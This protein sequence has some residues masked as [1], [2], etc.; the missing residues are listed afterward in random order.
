LPPVPAHRLLAFACSLTAAA[1]FAAVPAAQADPPPPALNDLVVES[2]ITKAGSSDYTA[3][4]RM[5]NGDLLAADDINDVVDRYKAD[6]TLVATYTGPG[7]G[8][9]FNSPEDVATDADGNFYVADFQAGRI[10]KFDS[11]GTFVDTFDGSDSPGH[12]LVRPGG[13]TV[14][15]ST[16]YVSDVSESRIETFT[17]DG[18]FQ[19]AFGSSGSGNGQ[20]NRPFGMAA[21]D[22]G[23]LYVAD[24]VNNRIEVFNSDGS[25]QRQWGSAGSNPG[26][27]SLPTSVSLDDSGHA[28]VADSSNTRGQKFTTAGDFLAEFGPRDGATFL[29]GVSW[30]G[31]MGVY[32]AQSQFTSST[33]THYAPRVEATQADAITS[34]GATLHGIVRPNGIATAYQFRW[35][36]KGH[37]NWHALAPHSAAGTGNILINDD[38]T[39]LAADRDYVFRVRAIPTG[40]D[41]E[42]SNDVE[43]TTAAVPT[44][45]AGD[46]GAPF[47][48]SSSSGAQISVP[49][50]GHGGPS[51]VRLAYQRDGG[52][53]HLIGMTSNDPLTATTRRFATSFKVMSGAHYTYEIRL[54]NNAGGPVTKGGEFTTP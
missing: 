53:G 2:V 37:G 10:V 51:T 9:D 34:T 48:L 54:F 22:A 1:A 23:D 5:P 39:G 4:N 33:I 49:I 6:G 38:V 29:F 12:T 30:D 11:S 31:A 8:D 17:L 20:L 47:V 7:P 52:P 44:P 50:T 26:Q 45:D 28:F 35:H 27:L 19:N 13:V 46:I 18:A 36:R 15:G 40:G 21:D 16:V 14:K 24:S 43:F 25:Y 32:A 41:P 3:V 42:I